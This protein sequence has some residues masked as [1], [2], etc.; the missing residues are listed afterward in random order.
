MIAVT[1]SGI[2]AAP[3]GLMYFANPIHGLTPMATSSR[4]S[5]TEIPNSQPCGDLAAPRL[6]DVAMGVSPWDRNCG[7]LS[8][9]GTTGKGPGSLPAAPSGLMFLANL[10]HGLTPMATSSRP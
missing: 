5:G 7:S 10:V 8:P 3:S 2:P 4:P 1:P 6:A 9:G